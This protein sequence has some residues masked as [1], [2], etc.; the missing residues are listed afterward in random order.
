MSIFPAAGVVSPTTGPIDFFYNTL[1]KYD[2]LVEKHAEL[3]LRGE[4]AKKKRNL[5][6]AFVRKTLDDVISMLK[7]EDVINNITE[8]VCDTTERVVSKCGENGT[9][10]PEALTK[11]HFSYL[12][13]LYFIP[14]NWAN[15]FRGL[16]SVCYRGLTRVYDRYVAVKTILTNVF[17]VITDTVL[18]T[19]FNKPSRRKDVG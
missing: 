9:V 5:S 3:Y 17:R 18:H 2:V 8:Y 16:E 15:E 14:A 19:I 13:G 12:Y 7:N 1:S 11:V 10:S 6:S 4:N